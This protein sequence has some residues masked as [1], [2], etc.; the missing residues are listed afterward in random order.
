MKNTNFLFPKILL[1]F[2]PVLMICSCIKNNNF[3]LGDAKIRFFQTAVS[4][5]SQNFYLNGIQIGNTVAYG[6]NTSYVVIPGDSTFKIT[7]RNINTAVD[8]SSLVGQ[9]FKIGMNYS[10]YYNK[11]TST[12]P[13]ILTVYADDVKP[14][15]DSAKLTFINLGYTLASSVLVIDSAKLTNFTMGLGE[16]KSFKVKVSKDTRIAFKLVTPTATNPPPAVTRLDTLSISNGK[17]YTILFDGSKTG[18]LQKRLIS[19]N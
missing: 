13:A 11:K 4:D 5:T 15:L 12:A 8:A 19:A 17:V 2:V 1:L 6:T 16:V 7:T 10:V 18:E 3:I 14:D 9:Q